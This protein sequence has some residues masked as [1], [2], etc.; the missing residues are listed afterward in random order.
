MSG[1]RSQPLYVYP[2]GFKLS[3]HTIRLTTFLLGGYWTKNNYNR[4][5]WTEDRWSEHLRR[6]SHGVHSI[7][8]YCTEIGTDNELGEEDENF[9]NLSVFQ[10]IGQYA[11]RKQEL[12]PVELT[13]YKGFSCL[14]FGSCAG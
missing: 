2:E 4:S 7:L 5:Y 6:L 10:N 3:F 12:M 14:T 11:L 9:S 13:K 8:T 1:I